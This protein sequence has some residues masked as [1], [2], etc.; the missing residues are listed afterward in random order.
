MAA[1]NP[2]HRVR[3]GATVVATA[4]AIRATWPAF[5]IAW[6]ARGLLEAIR[7]ILRAAHV[8]TISFNLNLAQIALALV[9][10]AASAVISGLLIRW[11]LDP[12][13]KATRPDRGL[14]G[15]VALIVV[16]HVI[17]LGVTSIMAPDMHATPLAAA[18]LRMALLGWATLALALV[19]AA[20]A[21]WPIG[22][23]VGDRLS[24]PRALQLMGRAYPSYVLAMIL[25]SLPGIVVTQLRVWTHHLP[26]SLPDRLWMVVI[27]SLTS[28][29][30]TVV[31][32]QIY[33][34]RLRGTDLP[35]SGS[36][37]SAPAVA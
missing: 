12:G 13:A 34:R 10:G 9:L 20:L 5:L 18:G 2:E 27:G 3:F 1:D 37:A 32:A 29:A 19:Y 16:S 24:F 23:L 4:R 31:L 11:L 14:A 15:Y 30:S 25:L 7:P 28:T 35:S 26:A 22:V 33:A 17:D 36:S 21:L 8:L 6:V